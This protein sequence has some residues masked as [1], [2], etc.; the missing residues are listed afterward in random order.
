MED[1]DTPAFVVRLEVCQRNCERMLETARQNG[2][3]LRPHVKTHKTV[4][5]G[6]LQVGGD[7]SR[8]IVCS[9]IAECKHFLS[10]G[11]LDVLY[12][13]PVSEAKVRRIA[14]LRLAFPDA[15]IHFMIDHIDHVRMCESLVSQSKVEHLHPLHQHHHHQQQQQQQRPFS[16]FLK[17]DCGYHRAGVEPMSAEAAE[18]MNAVALSSNAITLKGLYVHGGHSYGARNDSQIRQVAE[19]ERNALI[20]SAKLLQSLAPGR[21]WTSLDLCMGST[22]TCNVFGSM[23]QITE[24]HPGNY[25]FFDAMQ[26]EIG[27]C[28]LDQVACFVLSRVISKHVSDGKKRILVDAGALALSKDP[29]CSSKTSPL[30]GVILDRPDWMLVSISQEMGIILV[31]DSCDLDA[32]PIGMLLKILPQHSCLSAA[33]FDKYVVTEND[34]IVDTIRP[35]RGW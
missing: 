3:K 29:G 33:L 32:I 35:A 16:V 8:G 22:P 10:H 21:D 2:V 12:G 25:V 31:P 17:I 18:L 14:E 6:L 9:T 5:L 4:E 26:C 11:F 19:A 27:S 24:I 34:M 15:Q 13:V 28:R 20:E 23:D 7:R 1:L 30:Y